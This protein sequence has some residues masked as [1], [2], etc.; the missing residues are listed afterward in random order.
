MS[1]IFNLLKPYKTNWKTEIN[2]SNIIKIIK[3]PT[4]ITF[5]SDIELEDLS[6]YG[7]KKINN[8]IISLLK[9]NIQK[10]I[11]RN[12]PDV[13][14]SSICELIKYKSGLIQLLRRLCIIII[15]DKFDC[16]N[17]IAN[18]FN[19]LVWIMATEKAWNGWF[20]WLLGLVYYIC[21]KKFKYINN[22]IDINYEWSDHNY[23]RS[24]LI[25][26]F[27]GGLKCDIILLKN[28]AKIVELINSNDLDKNTIKIEL[29]EP[30]YNL[31]IIKASVDYHCSPKIITYIIQKY[32]KYKSEDIK[33][34]IWDYSSSIRFECE[35]KKSNLLWN[36]IK[37]DIYNYQKKYILNL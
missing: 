24:L 11:R 10:A 23:S 16:Y 25:R 35:K 36:T 19:T 18:H 31:K 21:D 28:C 34:A 7:D 4:S 9:S 1:N 37:I 14:I 12:L 22:N 8:E 26:S 3:K 15:E 20:N 2:K 17:E 6:N 13:A 27:Y 5:T 32:P 30:I 29:I 33:K